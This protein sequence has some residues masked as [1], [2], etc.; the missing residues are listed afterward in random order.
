M[1]G[2]CLTAIDQNLAVFGDV[3]LQVTIRGFSWPWVFLVSK[4]LLGQL[5][6]GI[7]FISKTKMVIDIG[8]SRYHFGFAP[9]VD[10]PVISYKG[11]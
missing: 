11:P 7:D 4:R 10:I 9:A 1:E 2:S 8:G 5:I 6:F 3:R